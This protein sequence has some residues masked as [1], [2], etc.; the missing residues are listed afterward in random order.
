MNFDCFFNY[1]AFLKAEI[2][3]VED[4]DVLFFL[5]S[6]VPSIDFQGQLGNTVI[7]NDIKGQS[8]WSWTILSKVM[9]SRDNHL[10]FGSKILPFV[11]KYSYVSNTF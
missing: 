4:V 8:S 2:F 9:T 11:F 1:L 5:D 10:G 6:T 3:L 7:G